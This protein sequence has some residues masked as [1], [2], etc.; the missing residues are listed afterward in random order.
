MINKIVRG[1]RLGGRDSLLGGR[2]M[3]FSQS[4]TGKV[5]GS[6]KGRFYLLFEYYLFVIYFSYCIFSKQM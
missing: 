1:C 3:V 6:N 5:S 4:F 2:I